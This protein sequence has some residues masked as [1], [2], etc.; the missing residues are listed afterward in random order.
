M[1]DKG[2]HCMSNRR[3]SCVLLLFSTVCNMIEKK[4][5]MVYIEWM[6]IA[7][8]TWDKKTVMF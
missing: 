5:E 6:K 4:I 2:A 1:K 8:N 3:I 7:S